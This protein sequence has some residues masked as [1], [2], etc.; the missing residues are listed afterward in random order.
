MAGFLPAGHKEK[1]KAFYLFV[2]R[3]NY[4]VIFDSAPTVR[5]GLPQAPR[6]GFVLKMAKKAANNSLK[7][8]D[9]CGIIYKVV[10]I[11]P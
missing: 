8:Q 6:G 1:F 3:L 2:S 4:K 7:I 10:K 11:K 9:F 5:L